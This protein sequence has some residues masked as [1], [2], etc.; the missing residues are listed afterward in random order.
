[1]K[2]Y[3]VPRLEEQNEAMYS[4]LL[5]LYALAA[6]SHNDEVLDL[7]AKAILFVLQSR[8]QT[9]KEPISPDEDTAIHSPILPSNF[10]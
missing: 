9:E 5:K 2:I 1:M 10:Y 6:Q 4:T 7:A 8:E 3:D